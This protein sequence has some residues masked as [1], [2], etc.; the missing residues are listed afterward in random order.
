MLQY[1]QLR[2]VI[3]ENNSSPEF[4]NGYI[5]TPPQTPLWI[6]TVSDLEPLDLAFSGMHYKQ[7]IQ[8]S[9]L[10]PDHN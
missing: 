3:L 2:Y 10:K 8:N 9:K 5:A 6:I 7:L 1:S 4:S